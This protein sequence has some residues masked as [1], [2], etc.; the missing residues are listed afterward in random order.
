MKKVFIL[1]IS[2]FVFSVP[3]FSAESAQPAGNA[4]GLKV[5]TT[6]GTVDL[7]ALSDEARKEV[8]RVVANASVAASQAVESVNVAKME[9]LQE[10][11]VA[12]GRGIGE[13]VAE[14]AKALNIAVQDFSETTVGKLTIALL[15]WKLVGSDATLILSALWSI[16]V[17]AVLLLFVMPAFLRRAQAIAQ[18]SYD[19]KYEVKPV[20]FGLMVRKEEVSRERVRNALSE[21]EVVQSVVLYA[22]AVLSG[23]VGLIALL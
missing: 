10:R 9:S 14:T 20:F 18:S 1:F 17:G 22:L 15:V 21:S 23:V 12:I 16:L 13:G 19:I 5:H 8:E 2:F 6:A 7:S 3:V 11:A 4:E